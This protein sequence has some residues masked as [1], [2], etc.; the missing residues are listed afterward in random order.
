MRTVATVALSLFF[1]SAFSQAPVYSRITLDPT[2]TVPSGDLFCLDV[3]PVGGKSLF[4][5]N[6]GNLSRD[7]GYGSQFYIANAAGESERIPLEKVGLVANR[8]DSGEARLYFSH[9]SPRGGSALVQTGGYLVSYKRE[10]KVVRRVRDANYAIGFTSE[11][12]ALVLT[13]K[14]PS[15]PSLFFAPWFEISRY[16]LEAGTMTPL[17]LPVPAIDLSRIRLVNKGRTLVYQSATGFER[18]HLGT[19]AH[20]S[21]T[22]PAGSYGYVVDR[23]GK[24]IYSIRKDFDDAVV[25][26]TSLAN[27][28]VAEAGRITGAREFVYLS[29][30]VGGRVLVTTGL[31]LV[32]EDTGN[33]WDAY[34]LDT[35]ADTL[36][37]VSRMPDGSAVDDLPNSIQFAYLTPDGG[38][39]IYRSKRNDLVAP[40]SPAWEHPF[41][42]SYRQAVG[43]LAEWIAKPVAGGG[44][45][46]AQLAGIAVSKNGNSVLYAAREPGSLR[47]IRLLVRGAADQVAARIVNTSVNSMTPLA[48]TD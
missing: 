29:D 44:A 46:L 31:G 34:L 45:N 33:G 17:T 4:I 21:F 26:R 41:Q 38:S 42:R 3:A 20:A 37:L 23:E 16:D 15:A 7:A 18:I 35:D 11:T 2:V 19:G 13:F 48:V 32:P 22:L 1:V 40:A 9:I 28:E 24:S 10:G 36:S 5:S 12:S 27:G 6:A 47:A 25:E 14:A 43:G 39:A 30:A 8:I